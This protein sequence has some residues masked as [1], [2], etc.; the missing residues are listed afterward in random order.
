MKLFQTVVSITVVLICMALTIAFSDSDFILQRIHEIHQD[1]FTLERSQ[2]A[3]WWTERLVPAL[4]AIALALF[5]FFKKHFAGLRSRI[6]TRNFCLIIILATITL[7][8]RMWQC[9]LALD[10]SYIDYRY[11][12]NW[13]NGNFDYNAGQHIMGFTSHLHLIVL[14]LVCAVLHT[15]EVDMVSFYLGC[16]L[17]T[18]SSIF[19]FLL[20]QK[21]YSRA[22]PAFIATLFFASSM[23]ACAEVLSGKETALITLTI[24]LALWSI[25]CRRLAFL[26]WCANALFLLR[27][28]GIFAC[29]T[30]MATALKRGGWRSLKNFVLPC[31]LTLAW[32]VFL[33]FYFGT[34]LPHGMVAKH[35]VLLA[36]DPSSVGSNYVIVLAALL[37]NSALGILLP[38]MGWSSFII[39]PAIVLVYTFWRL[40]QPCWV[41]CRNIA[42]VQMAFLLLVQPRMF[43]W[44]FCW[45]ALLGPIVIAQLVA[46]A[47][48]PVKDIW[49]ISQFFYRAILF[50]YIYCYVATGFFAI[51]YDWVPYIERGKLYREAALVLLE[52]TGGKEAIAA[53]DVGILGLLLSRSDHRLDGS[54]Q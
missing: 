30:V 49:K 9:P 43:G 5:L 12:Y 17:D 33:F 51:P 53:S 13:L 25:K 39:C 32:Y 2:Q 18:V 21:V 3:L 38:N 28:E 19:L 29:L 37:T 41:L 11:V 8:L 4:L 35:K 54:C 47:L 40:K 27:P 20:V 22:L 45:F 10:D 6:W 7:V 34:V 16:A 1:V 52:K 31:A 44:Y 46:D 26:P 14:W 36:G 42:I 15:N 50:L 23:F 24:L 48:L